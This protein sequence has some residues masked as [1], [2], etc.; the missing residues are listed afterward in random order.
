MC[1]ELKGRNNQCT[2]INMGQSW[3]CG[4]LNINILHHQYTSSSLNYGIRYNLGG[5]Y[6]KRKQDMERPK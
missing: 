5:T 4:G 1:T 6:R 2:V 3:E